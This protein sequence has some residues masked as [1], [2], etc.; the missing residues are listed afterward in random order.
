MLAELS[1][2]SYGYEIPGVNF[3]S[4]VTGGA[5][6]QGGTQALNVNSHVYLDGKEITNN[7]STHMA[8]DM[9]AQERSLIE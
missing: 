8:N 2:A 1:N 3:N 5:A 9:R 6:P 4:I 7:V